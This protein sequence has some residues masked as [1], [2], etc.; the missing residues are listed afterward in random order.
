MRLKVE[1][2]DRAVGRAMEHVPVPLG[3]PDR[4]LVGL[5]E[6]G[7]QNGSKRVG[8]RRWLVSG[9]VAATAL[10]AGVAGFLL[11]TTPP[12]MDYES[13]IAS[14][15]EFHDQEPAAE[16]E[17]LPPTSP[18]DEVYPCSL[19][20]NA[21]TRWRSVRNLLGRGGLAYDLTN[22]KGKH[23]TLYVVDLNSTTRPIAIASLQSSPPQGTSF[24]HGRTTGAWT[25][26][27]RLYVVVVEGDQRDYISFLRHQQGFA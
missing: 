13:V 3:L 18:W 12:P 9:S 15:G 8:R 14:V 19:A 2:V 1:Q 23:A 17:P 6:T 5:Q 27:T 16:G 21:R 22:G 24:F 11:R 25:D 7:L 10:A 20:T 4:L 26:G